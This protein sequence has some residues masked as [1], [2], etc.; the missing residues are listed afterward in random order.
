MGEWQNTRARAILAS[1]TFP[2]FYG[3]NRPSMQ[4]FGRALFDVALRC[5]GMATTWAGKH[6]LTVGEEHF[7]GRLLANTKDGLF[8]DV[9]ANSGNYARL[10]RT[11][12][13]RSRIYAFEP[14][15]QTFRIL[16]SKLGHDDTILVNQALSDTSGEMILYDFG[17]HD[18][19]TQ[20]SLSREAVALFS[21]DVVEHPIACTTLD[22]FIAAHAIERVDLLKI[23]T[24]GFDLAVLTGARDALQSGRVGVIQFEFIPANIVTGIRMRDFINLLPSHSLYRLCMNGSLI[25]LEPY[26]VTSCEI[27]AV[28]NIIALPHDMDP[29]LLDQFEVSLSAARN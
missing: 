16:Q 21:P 3:L 11:L 27:Y 22:A 26:D 24:E 15:P 23:D 28:Q 25:P 8:F 1:V 2:L 14:H 10:L 5:R 4:W 12:V 6:G 19:S 29:G 9:G 17:G 7:L 20:A 13:P 18:G